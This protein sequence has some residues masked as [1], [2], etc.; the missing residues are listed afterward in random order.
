MILIRRTQLINMI[1]QINK[2]PHIHMILIHKTL[3]TR[4]IQLIHKIL[5]HKN[6]LISMIQAHMIP[7]IHKI[8]FH[9]NFRFNKSFILQHL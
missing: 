3:L 7:L 6:L 1:P 5:T 2:T 9:K 4:K 8:L